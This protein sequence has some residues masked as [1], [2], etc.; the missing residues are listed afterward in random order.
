MPIWHR[1]VGTSTARVPKRGTYVLR[2]TFTYDN[3]PYG[4]ETAFGATPTNLNVS[5]TVC[6]GETEWRWR[7]ARRWCS[8]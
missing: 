4:I 5:A 3:K 7:Q 1:R 2:A 6:W 8:L